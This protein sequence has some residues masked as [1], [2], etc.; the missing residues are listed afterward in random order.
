MR[1][2]LL[3]KIR[4]NIKFCIGKNINGA[5]LLSYSEN[6]T[7]IDTYVNLSSLSDSVYLTKGKKCNVNV[8]Y[9]LIK[10]HVI[11]SD[12]FKKMFLEQIIKKTSKENKQ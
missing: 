12:S 9:S 10:Y 1:V 8:I 7:N 6:N 5:I 3:K 2:K 11:V 4:E